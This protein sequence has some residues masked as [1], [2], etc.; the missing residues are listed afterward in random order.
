MDK[1]KGLFFQGVDLTSV[2]PLNCGMKRHHQCKSDLSSED[3]GQKRADG[4]ARKVFSRPNMKMRAGRTQA[5]MKD[6]T[7]SK[8]CRSRRRTMT[9]VSSEQ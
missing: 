5:V 7:P 2:T 1:K 6:I 3:N 9:A 8:D 4:L